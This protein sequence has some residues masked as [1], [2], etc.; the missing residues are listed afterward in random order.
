MISKSVPRFNRAPRMCR[1]KFRGP[2]WSKLPP[3]SPADAAVV[4]GAPEDRSPTCEL[5]APDDL[6]HWARGRFRRVCGRGRATATAAA[7][8]PGPSRVTA[9]AAGTASRPPAPPLG[10]GAD[11]DEDGEYDKK[12]APPPKEETLTCFSP[13]PPPPTYTYSVRIQDRGNNV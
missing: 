5:R 3:S 4:E 11:G 7:T 13:P 10:H 2:G 9:A 6:V 1:F 8:A 12:V